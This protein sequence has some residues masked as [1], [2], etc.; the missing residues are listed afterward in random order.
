MHYQILF[1]HIFFIKHVE[2]QLC[3]YWLSILLTS[4][5]NKLWVFCFWKLL[6]CFDSVWLCTKSG[7]FYVLRNRHSKYYSLAC[8]LRQRMINFVQNLLNYITFE[9]FEANWS[10]FELAFSNIKNIDDL[11][12]SHLVFLKQ[13]LHDCMLT[14][15]KNYGYLDKLFNIC[16][17]FTRYLQKMSSSS[18]TIQS[19]NDDLEA[20]TRD[21]EFGKTILNYD[22]TFSQSLLNFLA[23]IMNDMSENREHCKIINI[24]NRWFEENNKWDYRTWQIVMMIIMIFLKTRFQWPLSGSAW[25]AQTT[26]NNGKQRKFN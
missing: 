10:I 13:S 4:I 17:M 9:V 1:R 8:A 20:L 14:N 2:R 12:E 16:L 5:T 25:K 7:E 11:I 6:F 19:T 26:K 23:Q 22:K 24:V 21:D 3:K 18:S 15:Y